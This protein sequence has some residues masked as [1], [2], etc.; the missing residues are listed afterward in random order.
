LTNPQLD[1][2]LK[3]IA[4]V[5][6]AGFSELFTDSQ[7][8]GV[9]EGDLHNDY[10]QW[11][12]QFIGTAFLVRREEDNSPERTVLYAVTAQHVIG[13][14]PEEAEEAEEVEM[15]E[16]SPTREEAR[17]GPNVQLRVNTIDRETRVLR[18]PIAYWLPYT[19]ATQEVDI[20]VLPIVHRRGPDYLESL[21]LEA[22]ANAN[23]GIGI[24]DRT[25]M[26]AMFD[27]VPGIEH[28]RPVLV[29]G[30]ISAM[31]EGPVVIK[32]ENSR[33]ETTRS[34]VKAYLVQSSSQGGMSG[35]PVYAMLEEL[36]VNPQSDKVVTKSSLYLLGM[37]QG[38]FG[39]VPKNASELEEHLK[40][41]QKSVGFY[42]DSASI[43]V[44]IHANYIKEL[45]ESES[46]E[47]DTASGG[48]NLR[49]RYF[50]PQ[51][52]RFNRLDLDGQPCLVLLLCGATA[53]GCKLMN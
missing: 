18:T 30:M 35:S 32:F 25:F 49:V 15:R 11:R 44:V 33:G 13:R 34:G 23:S 4:F 10:D 46:S 1:E 24:G 2:L 51:L 38:G 27:R 14:S 5:A 12:K 19:S 36:Q 37:L 8:E 21:S 40:A 42:H 41:K 16:I 28:I 20:S 26:V 48:C 43:G 53:T 52:T 9:I 29:A 3:P 17:L 6:N 7:F 50:S 31:P 22:F 47:C 45:I 39:T